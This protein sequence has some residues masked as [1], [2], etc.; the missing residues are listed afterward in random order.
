[1]G[2]GKTKIFTAK[3][4]FES[5]VLRKMLQ[6]LTVLGSLISVANSVLVADP[7]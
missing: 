6:E 5:Y 2:Y 7:K 3:E 1:M 4:R